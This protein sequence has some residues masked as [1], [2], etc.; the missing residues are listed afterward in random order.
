MSRRNSLVP[1]L[2]PWSLDPISV[3][4]DS[5]RMFEPMRRLFDEFE[6]SFE[7]SSLQRVRPAMPRVD[8]ID[9]GAVLKL[10]AELPGFA[11][12]DIE[13]TI[14]RNELT[15]RA[16]RQIE[17]PESYTV[18]RRER[19][20]V[21]ITRTFTLPCRVEVD[22]VKATLSNGVLEVV[23]PKAAEEQPRKIEIRPA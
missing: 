15:L 6:R 9:E 23:M 7:L 14:E 17:V 4:D 12:E 22:D 8:L 21:E 1:V 13:L 20:D 10:H 2:R 11:E 16:R 3:W 5:F 19:G 18:H